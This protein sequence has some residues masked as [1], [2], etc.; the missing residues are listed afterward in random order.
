MLQMHVY[1]TL[2]STEAERGQPY[3][4]NL[5]P[6]EDCSVPA[7]DNVVRDSI[8]PQFH[9]EPSNDGGNVGNETRKVEEESSG[10]GSEKMRSREM[11]RRQVVMKVQMATVR[12]PTT[13]T[14]GTVMVST[15][16]QGQ[17]GKFSTPLCIDVLL[18]CIY[19]PHLL[20]DKV[21]LEFISTLVPPSGSTTTTPM[22]EA[23]NEP[24]VVSSLPHDGNGDETNPDS[25]YAEPQGR[26]SKDLE[27]RMNG[28]DD[29]VA[30]GG[31]GNR[32]DEPIAS[33]SGVAE[34]DGK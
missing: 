33:A 23:E 14:V 11:V 27:P 13:V 34:V 32:D 30:F 1:A 21:Q 19:H 29:V 4:S 22:T 3:I 8:T 28:D 24:R 18:P 9:L 17:T 10:G 7:L 2:R 20:Y 31:P 6:F 25:E 16:A 26:C 5:M 12:T 15:L